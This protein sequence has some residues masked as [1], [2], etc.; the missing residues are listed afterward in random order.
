VREYCFGPSADIPFNRLPGVLVI[1]NFLAVGTNREE[2]LQLLDLCSHSH[3]PFGNAQSRR[4][5]FHIHRLVQKII[6]AS[7]HRFTVLFPS[8]QGGEKDDIRIFLLNVR[9]DHPAK[10]QTVEFAHNLVRDDDLRTL[11]Q[12]GIPCI[13]TIFPGND[14]MPHV[15]ELREQDQSG[16]GIVFSDENFQGSSPWSEYFS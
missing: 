9:S 5:L 1:P 16:H 6:S 2:A 14:S 12:K 13:L 7:L 8:R 11:G 10:V 3:N 4:Q 15:L